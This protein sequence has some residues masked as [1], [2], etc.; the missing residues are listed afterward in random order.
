MIKASKIGRKIKTLND[1]M[2]AADCGMYLKALKT[3][4]VHYARLIYEESAGND[5]LDL[6]NQGL[7]MCK[8]PFKKRD[9]IT[10]TVKMISKL[11]ERKMLASFYGA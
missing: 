9:K 5:I 2:N 11:Y 8:P 1:L 10:K 4:D 7:V 6:I 3:G